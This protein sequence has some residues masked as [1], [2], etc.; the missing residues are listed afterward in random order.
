MNTFFVFTSWAT[1]QRCAVPLDEIAE[2][3]ASTDAPGTT[4]ITLRDGRLFFAVEALDVLLLQTAQYPAA[5]TAPY[6][7]YFPAGGN[8]V[9]ANGTV[10]T[11]HLI[12]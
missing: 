6:W 10:M 2:L 8:G 3:Y 12:V 5:T 4:E 7:S 1:K 11:Y 9:A